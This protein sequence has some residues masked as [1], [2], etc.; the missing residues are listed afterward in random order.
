MF[1]MFLIAV[2]AAFVL[3]KLGALSVWVGVLSITLKAVLI[4]A[5]VAALFIGVAFA[6]R[7]YKGNRSGQ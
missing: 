5:I 3:I 6:W 2:A 1:W 4:A 7:H